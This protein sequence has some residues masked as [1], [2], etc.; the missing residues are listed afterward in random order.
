MY[1]IPKG[2]PN[3]LMDAFQHIA[4]LDNPS[5]DDLKVMVMIEAAGLQLYEDLAAGTE[6]SDVQDILKHN[7][8]EELA[9]A[10]RVSKAIGK[11]TG[12][13]YPV[14]AP[15]ENPYLAG[16]QLEP[17][18]VTRDMLLSLAEGEVNGEDLYERWASHCG[19]DEAAAL[20]RLNG[21]EELGHGQRLQQAAAL[22]PA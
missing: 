8:R 10:H 5:I 20:F 4:K 9:H 18:P 1:E 21:R 3:T 16:P 7:G 12:E 19:N 22:L 14:P 2:A 11:L 13:P 15:E 17:K 6:L